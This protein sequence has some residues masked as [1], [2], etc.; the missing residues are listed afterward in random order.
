MA[1]DMDHFPPGFSAKR[2]RTTPEQRERNIRLSEIQRER[3]ER[4]RKKLIEE[5]KLSPDP[6]P[7]KKPT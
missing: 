5:G 2:Y 4:N 1:K 3:D 6:E 7:V